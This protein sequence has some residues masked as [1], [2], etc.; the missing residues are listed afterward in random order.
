[1][2]RSGR[3]R[4]TPM[5]W[6]LRV[7]SALVLLFLVVPLAI[8]FPISFSASSSLM[9]PP[10]GWSLRWYRA[11]FS[12]EIWIE[13]TLRS[14]GIA[15]ATTVLATA[16]GLMLAFALVRGRFPGKALVNQ[17]ATA[18]LIVPSII[19][20]VAIYGLFAWFKLIGLWQGVV[21][22]HVV[23][24][25]PL[26]VLVVGAALRTVDPNLE[27]AA[28]GLGA[29]RWTAIRRVTLPQIRPAIV[30]GA[31]L[32]FIASFDELV[33][34]M[35]LGGS[36]WTLPKKMFD[37]IQ[38]EIEPTVAAVSVLQ[39]VLVTIVL[40]LAARFGAGATPI[41]AGNVRDKR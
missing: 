11:Y 26:V 30:S 4:G 27:L 3:R 36:N 19:Y 24:A 5:R 8:V 23:H 33:I 25:L 21:L 22:G 41:S 37:N 32:S 16:L 9:F 12:D 18:P 17:L 10:P 34:A 28:E 31:F 15:G 39:I 20:A 40:L 29:S 38:L 14:L 1:M 2:S 6:A 13:A 7:F 35:F